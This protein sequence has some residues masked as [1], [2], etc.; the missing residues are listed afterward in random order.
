MSPTE[1]AIDIIHDTGKDEK[2]LIKNTQNSNR[3]SPPRIDSVSRDF[4]YDPS[5]M[6]KVLRFHEGL[7]KN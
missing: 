2:I 6:Q 4:I 1:P 7:L 5:Q 3:F